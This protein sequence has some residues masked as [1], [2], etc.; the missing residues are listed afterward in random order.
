MDINEEQNP[1]S[2]FKE[3]GQEEEETQ[4]EPRIR[5][6][7]SPMSSPYRRVSSPITELIGTLQSVD[8]NSEEARLNATSI[9]DNNGGR[10]ELNQENIIKKEALE[11]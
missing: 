11:L 3:S 9:S 6:L 5:F 4:N 7:D 2:G 8:T 10:I 1:D